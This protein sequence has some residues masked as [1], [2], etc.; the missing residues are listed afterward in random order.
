MFLGRDTSIHLIKWIYKK[1]YI[2]ITSTEKKN[3]KNSLQKQNL[4]ETRC[5]VK[6]RKQGTTKQG[7]SIADIYN[8]KLTTFLRKNTSS[9]EVYRSFWVI[10]NFY[11]GKKNN[12]Y[13]KEGF[14]KSIKN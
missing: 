3:Q 11:F 1:R 7:D 13:V 6:K 12:N 4:G 9:K 10:L 14:F 2:P 5:H 8:K